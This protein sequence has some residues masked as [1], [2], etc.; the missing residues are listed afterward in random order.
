MVF[1]RHYLNETGRGM[2]WRDRMRHGRTGFGKAWQGTDYILG[3]E[4]VSSE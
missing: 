2:V 4:N 3:G 1:K